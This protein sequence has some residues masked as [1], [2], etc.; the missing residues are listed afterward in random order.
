MNYVEEIADAIRAEVPDH[1]L[2]P[3]DTRL[4]FLLY[5]LL[6]RS[7]GQNVAPEDVHDAWT[8]WMTARGEE[9]EA[10]VAYT[11]LDPETRAEDD[12]FV[13]AIRKVAGRGAT[14]E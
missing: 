7:K 4:L 10:L 9:H 5:A 12:P 1:L 11:S 2:P 8:V 3:G 6:A 13:A 14:S